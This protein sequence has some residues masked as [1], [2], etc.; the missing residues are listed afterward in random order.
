MSSRE[1]ADEI[2]RRGWYRRR[3]GAAVE[4]K[5]IMARVRTASY[6]G[7]YAID[8]EHLIALAESASSA[9]ASTTP[10]PHGWLNWVAEEFGFPQRESA[11]PDSVLIRPIW[12]EFVLYSDAN[13]EGTWLELGPN[14]V[15]LLEPPGPRQLGIARR[16]VLLRSW[17]HLPD[18][19]PSGQ[20]EV[21]TDIESYFGGDIGDEFAALLG[22]ALARRIRSG[23]RI[24]QGLPP[25][26]GGE[27]PR[28]IRLGLASEASHRALVL[29][30]PT[31]EPMIDW[32]ANPVSIG[33]VVEL[34]STYPRLDGGDAVALVRAARQYVD[35]LWLADADP[36]LAWIKLF[37][38]LEVAA[39]RFDD[40][41]QETP[42]A[43]LR[44]HRR[45]LA[46]ALDGVPH[47]VAETIA[48][49]VSRL[50]NVEQKLRR[51]VK[52]FDP[53]PPGVRPSQA[54]ARFDW[55]QLDEAIAT[56]YE[57]RSRDLHDGIAFPPPL[58][59]PPDKLISD[60][61]SERFYFL[62]TS[63]K[64]GQWT[65]E[66][67][68]MRLHVFAHIVGGALRLWWQALG[69]SVGS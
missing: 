15:I 20:Y 52:E 36:R 11:H 30:Q 27:R 47:D 22:L 10:G 60:R 34:I 4:A 16:T 49:E 32:L 40:G 56:L 31:R 54:P 66:D 65:A 46:K 61:P 67:L 14:D 3:D 6:S 9:D 68:P 69:A 23:G 41:R 59:E 57:H 1:L 44:R 55:D 13:V 45:R 12:E 2:N 29:E 43:Q 58:C 53:G 38:A 18:D 50:F 19:P 33:D 42:L 24:R 8:S 28:A 48:Q 37:S 17:D 63:M 51:F 62:G 39:N 25:L 5:Q 64:G 26:G 35:G 21:E 7:R